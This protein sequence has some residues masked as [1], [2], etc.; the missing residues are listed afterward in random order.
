MIAE[1]R[2]TPRSAGDYTGQF[3]LET[4]DPDDPTINIELSAT[5]FQNDG[6]GGGQ[7]PPLLRLSIFDE[8]GN[9]VR[10]RFPL[11]FRDSC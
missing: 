5:A 8:S 1:I 4:D 3:T 6:G 9:A 10:A 11:V 7:N 2:F